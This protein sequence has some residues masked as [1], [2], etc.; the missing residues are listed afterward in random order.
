MQIKGALTEGGERE[1][2]R[3][4][5]GRGRGTTC[6]CFFPFC[7]GENKNVQ[8]IGKCKI[9]T[10]AWS[11]RTVGLTDRQADRQTTDKEPDREKERQDRVA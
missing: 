4:G 9:A 10:I 6:Q 5:I 3:E 8:R 2:Q 1:Q 11:Q 7:G